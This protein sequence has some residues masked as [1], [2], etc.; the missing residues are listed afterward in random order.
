VPS[1]SARN[2]CRSARLPEV[3][4]PATASAPRSARRMSRGCRVP[5]F[6]HC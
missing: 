3:T 2:G 4:D 1:R 5:G 6:S